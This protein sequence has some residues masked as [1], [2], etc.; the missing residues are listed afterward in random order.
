MAEGTLEEPVDPVEER[1]SIAVAK[2]DNFIV[3]AAGGNRLPACVM[4]RYRRRAYL[5]GWRMVVNFSDGVR[6]E[7]HILADEHFPYTAPRVVVVDGPDV[8][9]WPHL[10]AD[11]FLCVLPP[12]SAVSSEDTTGVVKYVL[13]EACRLIEDNVAGTN[14][15]D[16]RNE[17][18]SYWELV[19][20]KNA[21][22]FI[23]LLDPQGPSRRVSVWRGLRSRVVSES[24][25]LLHRWLPRWGAKKGKGQDYTLH[26][27]ILIWLPE[28]LLPQEYPST[29]ADV[30]ALVRKRSSD[31]VASVL[32]DLVISGTDEIN[33]L[34]GAHTP[35]GACFSAMILRRPHQTGSIRHKV[36][37]LAK[38]FRPGHVPTN[39]LA[40][41]YLSGAAKAAK[42]RVERADHCWIHGRDQDPRQG[43]LRHVR[44][45][46]LGC[47]S[48]GGPLARL[49]A[50]AGVGNLL[51]VDHDTMNWPNVGRHVLGAASV[52]R[53][54]APE[55]V[56]ELERAY[57][58]LGEI[59]WRK[60]RVGPK[61]R[62]LVE[63][64]VSYDLVVSVMG[65]WAGESFLNE[66]HRKG[67]HHPPILYG[68]LEPHAA[69]A[70]AVFVTRIG[71]CLRCGVNDKG[72]P[73]LR[74]TDWPGGGD[75]QTP[76]CGARFTPYGPSELCWA[77]AL[78][79][80]TAIDA[81]MGEFTATSHRIWIG[82]RRRIEATGGTWATEWIMEM[83]DPGDGGVTVSRPWPESGS[84]PVCNRRVRA[85]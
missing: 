77:H 27:G 51:L 43:R 4:D 46:I 72:N 36:D 74:V 69:A 61:A 15:E 20:D 3:G 52:N 32:E 18:L 82:S 62:K 66:I 23:S 39:L 78:L 73:N 38:G 5:L 85:T 42:A 59:S 13:A 33:V 70:H 47:G 6:R 71:A 53:F 28:P 10:E 21:P 7:L 34:M 50:Q 9:T 68:W 67:H 25:Q 2:A 56:R 57:P 54:K 48:V 26:D 44:V 29:S 14:V 24:P 83:G 16:F 22:K 64:L 41:R 37:L 8:L 30:R 40:E 19:I 80:E 49:L 55:L 63:E 79:A 60:E 76:T 12:D 17:F 81:L 84:C 11:G 1:R 31:S 65:N 45:A 35:N 75:L 58:H